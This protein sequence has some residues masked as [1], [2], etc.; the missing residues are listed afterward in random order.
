MNDPIQLLSEFIG[1]P[2]ARALLPHL[3][4]VELVDGDVL[5]RE[6]VSSTVMYLVVD[7]AVD[8]VQSHRGVSVVVAT[9][10]SGSWV[11]EVGFIDGGPSTATVVANGPGRALRIKRSVLINLATEQPDPAIALMRHLNR[12]V[13]LRLVE[14]SAGIIERIGD[15]QFHIRKVAAEETSDWA[16]GVLGWLFGGRGQK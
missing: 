6:G 12:Q 9:L 5:F 2:H 13:A 16:S 14:S 8:I 10:R 11:G 15:G 3:H 4:D 1:E 7:G